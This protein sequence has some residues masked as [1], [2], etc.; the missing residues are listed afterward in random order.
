MS[1]E[2]LFYLICPL[3]N[4]YFPSF[5]L[6]CFNCA[7]NP[8]RY[9]AFC[10][11]KLAANNLHRQTIVEAGAPEAFVAL[12]CCESVPAQKQVKNLLGLV[13]FLE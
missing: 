11:G 2:I 4:H 6:L 12:L 1:V 5:L 13:F 7:I 9:A 3:L 8:I 10:L